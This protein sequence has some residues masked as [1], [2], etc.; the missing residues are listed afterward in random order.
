M[1]T[2]IISHLI[3]KLI[4]VHAS[5]KENTSTMMEDRDAHKYKDGEWKCWNGNEE[6]RVFPFHL[7]M[8][9]L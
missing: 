3:P 2:L 9:L 8:A 7:Q 5:G 1:P 6:D 4:Y